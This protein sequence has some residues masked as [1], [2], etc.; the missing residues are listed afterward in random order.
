ML[1]FKRRTNFVLLVTKRFKLPRYRK[2]QL[3][4]LNDIPMEIKNKIYK[5]LLVVVEPIDILSLA[6]LN[7]F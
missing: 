1:S 7:S 6:C 3:T 5:L 2:S 4:F